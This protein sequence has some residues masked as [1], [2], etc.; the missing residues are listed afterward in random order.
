MT[1]PET[2]SRTASRDE[3]VAGMSLLW[4]KSSTLAPD[5]IG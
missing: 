3:M 1:A 2:L 5:G 4:W